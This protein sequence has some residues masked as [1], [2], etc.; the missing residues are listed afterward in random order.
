[1]TTTKSALC[2]IFY[3]VLF[4]AAS[5]QYSFAFG[6]AGGAACGPGGCA[7]QNNAAAAAAA[8]AAANA[9]A[10]QNVDIHGSSSNSS[11][12][13]NVHGS[14]S[15][16]SA[17]I[18]D[19]DASSRIDVDSP[20]DF[21]VPGPAPIPGYTTPI[22]PNNNG[23]NYYSTRAMLPKVFFN[24]GEIDTYANGSGKITFAGGGQQMSGDVKNGVCVLPMNPIGG[25]NFAIVGHDVAKTSDDDTTSIHQLGAL[26]RRT[27]RRGGNA[28][29]V[30]GDGGVV[31]HSVQF[32]L[33]LLGG[34]GFVN[35]AKNSGNVFHFGVGPSYGR[36]WVKQHPYVQGIQI[37]IPGS[38]ADLRNICQAT[39][40]AYLEEIRNAQEATHQKSVVNVMNNMQIP[41]ELLQ[42]M[43]R[44]QQG[45]QPIPGQPAQKKTVGP[46]GVP[47]GKIQTREVR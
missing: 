23:P 43:P 28:I 7:N 4:F 34:G 15:S 38:Y 13:I 36:A 47:Q 1:M 8:S 40:I 42:Q 35:A 10:T 30:S 21:P 22:P 14:S 18:G 45:Y 11:A 39:Y 2:T 32:T 33:A 9:N 5:V 3:A 16:S 19:I 37:A 46:Q 31:N 20:R 29:I 17:N 41:P 12:N 44:Q 25:L 6:Q 26:M 24:A 27:V